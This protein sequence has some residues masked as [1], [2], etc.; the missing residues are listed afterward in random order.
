MLKTFFK[1]IEPFDTNQ[2][3]TNRKSQI[4]DAH[5]SVAA[6]ITAVVVLLQD[7]AQA[8]ALVQMAAACG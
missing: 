2:N 4:D 1:I 7:K 8:Q 6:D 3:S 5:A